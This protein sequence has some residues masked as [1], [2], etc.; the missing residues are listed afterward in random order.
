[1]TVKR[2]TAARL[3]GIPELEEAFTDTTDTKDVW[4][5]GG[6]QPPSVGPHVKALQESLLAMGYALPRFGADGIYG[7]ET[8]AAVTQLQIDA[9]HPLHEGHEWEH[10]LGI[11]GPNT[12]VHFDMFDPGETVGEAASAS[13]VVAAAA[14]FSESPDNLFA[15]FDG[16]TSPPTLLVGTRT[17]RRVRVERQPAGATVEF[18]VAD[19]TVATVGLTAEGIVVGGERAGKTTIRASSDGV[20][21]AELAVDVRDGREERVNFFFVADASEPRFVTALD[22]E[23]ATLF[24]LRLNRVYRRQANVHFTLGRVEDVALSRPV[25]PSFGPEFTAQLEPFAV[26]G[27][28]NVFCVW[29]APPPAPGADPSIVLLPDADCSDKMT[30]PHAAAHYLAGG[31]PLPAEGLA[32]ACGS[33]TD[34]RRITIA[35]A[36]AMRS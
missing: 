11:A 33:G 29:E 22:H 30:L 6:T 35:L 36:D 31:R 4:D 28:L 21:L 32:T 20:V 2:L 27:E 9:G 16:S 25:G 34:R 8:T 17:R 12:M 26:P 23:K 5:G 13:G 18:A 14:V 19:P 24:T 15:G 10:V 1:V 3:A 7:A